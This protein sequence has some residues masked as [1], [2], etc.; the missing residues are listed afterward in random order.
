M[1]EGVRLHT[2]LLLFNNE[3]D[4]G[5]MDPIDSGHGM[6]PTGLLNPIPENKEQDI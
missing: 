5:T 1:E 2:L 4:V 6:P 3:L